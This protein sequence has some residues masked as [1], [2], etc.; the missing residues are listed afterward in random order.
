VL[1]Q[2]TEH[3]EIQDRF[4]VPGR[5]WLAWSRGLRFLLPALRVA[6]LGC[7]DG[8]V[9][10][11]IAGWAAE[12]IAVDCNEALLNQARERT[13]GFGNIKFR[14]E[15]MEELS[16]EDQS[17]DLA[18]FSQSLHYLGDPEPAL[19][20]AFRILVPGGRILI[21]DLLMH[22]ETWVLS[23]LHH[24][25]LGYEASVMRRLLKAAGFRGLQLDT[26]TKQAAEPFRVLIA[27]GAKP[28]E[29]AS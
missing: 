3:L 18:L 28:G 25:Q 13:S 24:Q 2:R 19:R 5:S 26:G 23:Q 8:T 7:G 1:K 12:I 6:D 4:V 10:A 29:S 14:L 9:T 17:V 21:L 20:E 27:T 15:S 16:L 22:R 11:E